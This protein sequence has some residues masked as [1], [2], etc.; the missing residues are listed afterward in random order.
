MNDVDPFDLPDW[1]GEA[2][3]V[4]THAHGVRLDTT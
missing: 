2:E 4:W 3:V 1:L